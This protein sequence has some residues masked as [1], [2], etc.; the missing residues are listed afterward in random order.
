MQ[1]PNT[2]QILRINQHFPLVTFII[3]S[4]VS[5][6]SNFYVDKGIF[7]SQILVTNLT[8]HSQTVI[9]QKMFDVKLN[10]IL[11]FLQ[12]KIYLRSLR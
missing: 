10:W 6:I 11:G 12:I 7:F 1:F 2:N 4:T 8:H 9:I 5:I 3:L